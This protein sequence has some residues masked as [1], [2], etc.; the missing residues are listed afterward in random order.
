MIRYFYSVLLFLL[1]STLIVNAQQIG[2]WQSHTAKS[3]VSL[4]VSDK[5]DRIWSATEGGLFVIDGQEIVDQFTPAEGMYRVSPSAM[6]YDEIRHRIWLGYPDG[7]F[8]Y[9]DIENRRFRIIRDIAR[10]EQYT[11]RGINTML[12]KSDILYIATDFGIVIYNTSNMNTS[13]TYFNLGEFTAGTRV[14]DIIFSGN[15][16]Y[17]ATPVG[18]AMGDMENDNLEDPSAWV[19]YTASS[20]LS[21]ENISKLGIHNGQVYAASEATFILDNDT[22]TTTD[23]FDSERVIDFSSTPE[24]DDLIGVTET[25]IYVLSNTI[26][27]I[28]PDDG[29]HFNTAL[30][31]SETDQLYLGTINLGLGIIEDGQVTNLHYIMPPGPYLNYFM[32]LNFDGETI[33]SGSSTRPGQA[34]PL[35]FAT[36]G[37]YLYRD[38]NWESYNIETNEVLRQRNFNSA[39]TSAY[40][41]DYYFFGSWGQGIARHHKES[42]DIQVFNAQNS[43][44]T[45][46]TGGSNFVVVPGISTDRDGDL[47]IV[48]WQFEQGNPLFRYTPETEEW[49]SYPRSSQV[50]AS[51]TYFNLKVDTFDQKW[52]TLRSITEE[53]RGLLVLRT[54]GESIEE[55]VRLSEGN[56]NIP[57]DGV[58]ALVQDKRGEMWVG[59]DRG[60]VRFPFPDRVVIGN[61]ADRQGS[62]LINADTTSGSA[63]LLTTIKATSIAVNAANEKWIGT[64]GDGLWL[65][66]EEGGRHRVKLHF[67][68]ENS[69]LISNNI[70]SLAVDDETGDVFIATDQGLI[71]YTD[72]TRGGEPEM[73]GLFIYPN[74]FSYQD[75]DERIVIDKLSERATVSIVGIDGRLVNRMETFGGRVEWNARDHNGNRVPTGVYMVIAVD[76][77]DG[78]RGSGKVVI[79]R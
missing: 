14:Q 29:A 16:L 68:T 45:G 11:P 41:D 48:S 78:S 42:N 10:A 53:G 55:S 47:W 76:E 71:T 13:E 52:I 15:Q 27:R 51:H 1:G 34:P 49:V 69:P 2:T 66:S 38:G 75:N 7:T 17:A 39:F 77:E 67:T 12:M 57:S 79:V 36:T 6:V 24:G 46:I 72:V 35:P 31:Q 19:N 20:G 28:E 8:E 37:Y 40:T 23:I 64:E 9:F 32:G 50:Q 74:P 5:D 3:T 73:A 30:F 54:D 59:T 70:I 18:I 43:P 25:V 4:I 33:I 62:R 21:S 26:Q 60:V 63:F 44:L 56:G 58:N 65:I 22:W 61:A